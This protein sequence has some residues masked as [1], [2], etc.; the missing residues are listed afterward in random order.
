MYETTVQEK[1]CILRFEIDMEI[2]NLVTGMKSPI[3]K[4]F[5]TL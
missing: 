2:V 5:S 4:T 3:N 1:N